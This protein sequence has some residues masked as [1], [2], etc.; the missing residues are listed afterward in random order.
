MRQ[1]NEAGLQL[2]EGFEKLMLTAY[3]PVPTDPWT[4]GWGHA[5]EDVQEGMTIT[6]AE[7]DRL[8]L[9]DLDDAERIVV[10]YVTVP[11]NDNQF[12][13]LVSFVF[14]VGPGRAGEKSGFVYL[15]EGGTSSMLKLLNAGNY[16]DA[17]RQFPLWNRAGGKVLA[18]LTN[19]RLAEQALFNTP[20]EDA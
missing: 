15:K 12:S 1:I 18:G 16:H 2:I 20:A 10:A 14:N 5:G 4:I 17:S 9:H 7:A 3:K 6:E 13:A 8:L 11:L 19:R